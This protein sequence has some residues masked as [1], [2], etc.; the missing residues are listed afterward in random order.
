LSKTTFTFLSFIEAD[1]NWLK[2]Q[3]Q[4]FLFS[5]SSIKEMKLPGASNFFLTV[6]A[7]F[8][9]STNLSFNTIV[10]AFASPF[11]RVYLQV[12]DGDTERK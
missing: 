8:A 10:S 7:R 4:A 5:L 12:A 11:F 2:L 6:Q 1:L 3:T 9:A